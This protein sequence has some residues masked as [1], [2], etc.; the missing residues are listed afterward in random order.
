MPIVFVLGG[1]GAS[2]QGWRSNAVDEREIVRVAAGIASE[3]VER[4]P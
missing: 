4:L 1:I 3:R 2:R